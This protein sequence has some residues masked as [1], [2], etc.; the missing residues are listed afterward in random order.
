VDPP[1][2]ERIRDD[3]KGIVKGELLFDDLS[4]VL[5][6][7][8]ASIFEVEPAGVV[9]PR[10]EE[11][12]QALVRYAGEHQVPLTAR[13]A[14]TGVAGESLG[15]GLIVDLS[16]HFRA[17]VDIGADTVRI[18]PGVV[19]RDL[20][21]EL[22]R[23][24]RRFAPDPA[25]TECTLGGM[26]ANN[27]SGARALRHGFTRDHVVRLRAVLDNGDA[28]ELGRHSRWPT[29]EG[30]QGRLDDIVSSVVT[31]LEEHAR[32]IETCRPRTRFNR[33]GY[34]L[35][36]VLDAESLDLARLVIGSE[37]TLALFTEATLRTIPLPGG[38]G[39]VL[40]GFAGLDAAL[41]AAGLVAPTGA[42]ACE[43]IDQRLL[44]LA[45][46]RDSA[47]AELLPT[48][49]ESLLLVE[50]EADT[51]AEAQ[52]LAR[53][54]AQRL[55]RLERLAIV[56]HVAEDE[57]TAERF[58]QVRAAALPSLYSL[59]GTAQ[60]LAFVEDVGVPPES[61]PVYLH[62]VQEV[63]QR[64]EMTAS[65][66]I[67]AATGQV[68]MRPFVEWQGPGD[69]GRLWALAD[70][71]YRIVLELGGTISA[72][73]GT[74]LARTPWVSRQAGTLFPV[75]RE[76]KSI[77]DPRHLFNPGKIIGPATGVPAW[78]LR[79][80]RGRD[81]APL[82]APAPV[83]GAGEKSAANGEK[84]NGAT[85][86]RWPAGGVAA[87]SMSCNGCGDCRTESPGRRMCPLFRATHDEAATPRAKAN[88]MRHLLQP[89][90]DP[91]LSSSDDVRAVADLCVNCKMCAHE[92][93]AHVNVPKLMLEA[94]A[95]NVAE[96][97]LN[98]TDWAMARTETFARL[99]S[100]FA[101]LANALLD[102]QPARWLLEKLFGLSR[103]RRLPAFASRSFLRQ[104][105]RRGWTRRPRSAR[106]SVA[107]FVD[108]F[109]NYNDPLIAEAVVAVL[110]HN[111]I[112]V[113]VP[114]HQRGCGMAPL[115][116][117]DIEAAR[118]TVQDNLLELADL[119]RDG[120]PILCS[121]PTAALMLRHDALDLLDDAD[122][123]LVA[124]QT[125]E[126]TAFLWD[127]HQLG[128]LRTD[129]TPL[130]FAVGHHVPCHLKAL[131]RPPVGPALLSL[132]PEM[133][134]HTIDV[135]C[136]GMAGTFG[137]KAE[138]YAASIQAGRPML[139][140][141]R[142]PR[143]LFGSTECSTCRIQ[144][145]DAGAVRTLHPAQYLA[146]AYGYLPELRRRLRQPIRNLVLR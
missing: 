119:A 40:L 46:S 96:H 104:A 33:C 87:E 97:G 146:L 121:E 18:Q 81:D 115:A 145:E 31:L 70:D 83:E 32:T 56:A 136:S 66:L 142:R 131:G 65:Y 134:V 132:I 52:R 14:G 61:L 107:Y 36:D 64:H 55:H 69:V 88:L 120:C 22:A 11:D 118:E 12:V 17:I 127:L 86:L 82:T 129:F 84:V 47:I 60:P 93:P 39:V 27:A 1:Q 90:T 137:L 74:G 42:A 63:L 112:E 76:L 85:L 24:G 95:A 138:N 123:R 57:E 101:P 143:V 5:Y 38:R 73:H 9:V 53:D 23:V 102:S 67:H 37:G 117:G 20:A 21:R 98:L 144:M 43:L 110:H 13:G 71:V 128:N 78:P 4:R 141:L 44:R 124:A 51:P 50:Y 48:A 91:R 25:G 108:I 92:C 140:E 30:E 3:L 7:T 125:V 29:A 89:G 26:L 41:R 116:Y 2:R 79:R 6:S 103:H 99:G 106:P 80:R 59:R 75:F 94:K 139:E 72:Q 28:V 114:P 113:Y 34:A 68:H 10:D 122:A 135:S 8:D 45:R 77:F 35:Q 15:V 126:C 109:A 54:L 111:G 133:R 19:Y 62:R 58:W 16:K 105:H 130:P 100:A 49:V